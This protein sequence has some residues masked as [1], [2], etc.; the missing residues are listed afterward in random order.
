MTLQEI[1][2]QMQAKVAE[3]GAIDGKVVTF[4]F[5]EDGAMTID[6]SATPPAVTEG[7]AGNADCTVMVS[8]DDFEEIAAGEQNAQ[9]AFMSGK[10][11]VEGDM[12][13]AMQLGSLLS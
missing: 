4:D 1:I 9:M 13:I 6:G 8:K 2:S 7:N 12:G 5:A 11:K 3:K 10:L